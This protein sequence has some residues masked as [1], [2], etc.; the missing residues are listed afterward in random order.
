MT[1]RRA[2]TANTAISRCSAPY[3]TEGQRDDIHHAHRG[4]HDQQRSRPLAGHRARCR[5]EVLADRVNHNAIPKIPPAASRPGATRHPRPAPRR[6]RLRDR[7]GRGLVTPIAS[8]G[9]SSVDGGRRGE[10]RRAERADRETVQDPPGRTVHHPHHHRGDHH[11][12]CLADRYGHPGEQDLP[13][14]VCAP[15]AARRPRRRSGPRRAQP[16]ATPNAQAD[17]SG[18]LASRRSGGGRSGARRCT[19]RMGSPNAVVAIIGAC[20]RSTANPASAAARTTS[21]A[22]SGCVSAAAAAGRANV[23]NRGASTRCAGAAA[24]APRRSAPVRP[25]DRCAPHAPAEFPTVALF[26]H[27]GQ[28]AVGTA[29]P[30]PGR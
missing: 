16:N 11:Q 5:R 25:A 17:D 7:P 23:V 22:R 3:Q 26:P 14:S 4:H 2:N 20:H 24:Y 29:Y 10:N 27:A 18:D 30:P 13:A 28:C 19:N 15:S 1:I 6:A 21:P 12:K 9:T 8:C